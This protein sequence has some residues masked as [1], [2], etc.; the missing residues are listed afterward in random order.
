[1]LVLRFCLLVAIALTIVPLF[2]FYEPLASL[3][4]AFA[5]NSRRGVWCWA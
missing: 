1:M 3:F 2:A 5:R 4:E